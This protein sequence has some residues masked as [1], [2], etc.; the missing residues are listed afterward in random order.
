MDHGGMFAVPEEWGKKAGA[1]IMPS[2]PE[3]SPGGTGSGF[4]GSS[5]RDCFAI[6]QVKDR[7]DL[8]FCPLYVAWRRCRK[9]TKKF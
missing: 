7:D 9:K 6:Y 3:E 4:P 1:S 8:R 5:K 2:G